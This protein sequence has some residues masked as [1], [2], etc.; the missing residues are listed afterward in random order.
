[1]ISRRGS[2]KLASLALD[3]YLCGFIWALLYTRPD[4][5]SLTHIQLFASAVVIAIASLACWWFV[6]FR[7]A[8]LHYTQ[9]ITISAA[10]Y[11]AAILC[12]VDTTTVV[13]VVFAALSV[14]A[15]VLYTAAVITSNLYGTNDD[16]VGQDVEA[17]LLEGSPCT[18]VT[19]N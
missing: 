17:G 3:A 14:F 11:G 18:Y 16:V 7:R 4:V 19:L 13:V 2:D 10:C 12:F 8:C 9:L 5:Q 6:S 1:M 15:L